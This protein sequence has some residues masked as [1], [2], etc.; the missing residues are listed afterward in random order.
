MKSMGNTGFW[1][2]LPPAS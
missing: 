2:P 1:A